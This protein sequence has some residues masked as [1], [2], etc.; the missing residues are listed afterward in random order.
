MD[1]Q[2]APKP[3][4]APCMLVKSKVAKKV[5][6]VTAKQDES[7]YFSDVSLVNESKTEY[8]VSSFTSGF[9]SSSA[10]SSIK[11]EKLSSDQDFGYKQEKVKVEIVP[12]AKVFE[13]QQNSKG[14]N[15]EF[16]NNLTKVLAALTTN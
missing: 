3:M 5:V 4:F 13:F 16:D 8:Q 9:E 6:Q 10:S 12:N 11:I 1:R 7:I 14:V 15:K 2:K